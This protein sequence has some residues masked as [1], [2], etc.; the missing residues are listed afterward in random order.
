MPRKSSSR[1]PRTVRGL[2]RRT[3]SFWRTSLDETYGCSTHGCAGSTV[4]LEGSHA[5][6]TM[7]PPEPDPSSLHGAGMSAPPR[8]TIWVPWLRTITIPHEVAIS[9]PFD[10]LA[11]QTTTKSP[12]YTSRPRDGITGRQGRA[13][14][15]REVRRSLQKQRRRTLP[16]RPEPQG[17]FSSRTRPPAPEMM[18][19]NRSRTRTVACPSQQTGVHPPRTAEHNIRGPRRES[20]GTATRHRSK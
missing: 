10:S 20:E 9:R 17:G 13:H 4:T 6:D 8:T 15:G 19:S 2:A 14:E 5:G 1:P 7:S 18:S 3:R 11:D 16:R 12:R